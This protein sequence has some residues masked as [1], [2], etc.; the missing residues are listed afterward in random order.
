[1]H[2]W[3]KMGLK[4]LTQKSCS[5]LHYLSLQIT[6]LFFSLIGLECELVPLAKSH[7]SLGDAHILNKR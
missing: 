4:S 1:M 7:Y 3:T 2:P 6:S 5:F